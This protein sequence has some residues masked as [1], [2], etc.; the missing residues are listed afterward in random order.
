[1]T[2]QMHKDT[3]PVPSPDRMHKDIKPVPEPDHMR[4]GS[5]YQDTKPGRRDSPHLPGFCYLIC[6]SDLPYLF[7]H[8]LLSAL[9]LS[10]LLFLP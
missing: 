1:M 7:P 10:E 9:F 5:I 4:K 8:C 6:L 2:D 3:N